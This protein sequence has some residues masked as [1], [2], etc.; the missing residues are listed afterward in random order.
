ML[1]PQITGPLGYEMKVFEGKKLF[2]HFN[3]YLQAKAKS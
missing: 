2:L 1:D 3:C